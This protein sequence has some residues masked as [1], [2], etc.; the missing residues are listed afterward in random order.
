M[1]RLIKNQCI[2]LPNESY[3][4]DLAVKFGGI[5]KIKWINIYLWS[6]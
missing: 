1:A 3:F 2:K 4:S 6:I 5:L